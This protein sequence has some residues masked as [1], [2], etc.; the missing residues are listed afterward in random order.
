M[1]YAHSATDKALARL[2]KK[3]KKEYKQAADEVEKKLNKYLEQF[4]EKNKKMLDK[5]SAKEI[6]QSEYD[7][8]RVS[9]MVLADKW[10]AT[11]NELVSVYMDADKVAAGLIKDST[12]EVYALNHN[13]SVLSIEKVVPEYKAYALY[14]KETVAR[15]VRDNPRLLPPPGKRTSQRIRDRKL[16]RW[17]KQQIQSVMLQGILQGESIPK[18]AKRL[19]DTVGDRNM[20][21][22]IRNARTMT[23][24]AENAG[25]LAGY[26]E[27][28]EL[29]IK[30]GKKWIATLDDR[31]RHTHAMMDG[32][33]VPTNEPFSNGLMFPADPDGEPEEVYN[34]RC[35]MVADIISV[36]GIN[37]ADIMN[38]TE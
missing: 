13:Y 24:S 29:G 19:A 3:I 32:E 23:T 25:R 11:R 15:L 5:L 12:Y 10:E 28:E 22:A 2:E 8:W 16:K 30:M 37:I 6:T 38:E 34:C 31:T 1:D 20:H 21:S 35:T 9:Q 7:K 18:I 36:N 17:N 26:R 14:D 27:A 4:A 33:V